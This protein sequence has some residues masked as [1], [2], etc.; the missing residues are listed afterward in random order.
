M[1]RRVV[2][3]PQGLPADAAQRER[4][5]ELLLRCGADLSRV[6]EAERRSPAQFADFVATVRDIRDGLAPCLVI[7]T[8]VKPPSA[9]VELR[10]L[11]EA[12]VP[13]LASSPWLL[14]A[15]PLVEPE[16]IDALRSSGRLTGAIWDAPEWTDEDGG[17]HLVLSPHLRR[18]VELTLADRVAGTIDV[19]PQ[20]STFRTMRRVRPSLHP[21]LRVPAMTDERPTV[22]APDDVKK[23]A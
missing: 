20:R 18:T 14:Y 19:I 17:R 11:I 8:R 22:R 13:A 16:C 5:S 12:R 3:A 6:I 21:T 9:L 2:I 15:D 10:T 7:F 23:T 4:C 1:V